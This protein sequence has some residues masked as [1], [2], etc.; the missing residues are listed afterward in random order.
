MIDIDWHNRNWYNPGYGKWEEGMQKK[1]NQVVLKTKIA[2]HGD[3]LFKIW[4]RK[5]ESNRRPFHYE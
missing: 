2:H 3:V 5:P 4:S 1:N